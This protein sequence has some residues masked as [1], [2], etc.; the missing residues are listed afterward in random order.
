MTETVK[1][2]GGDWLTENLKYQKAPAPSAFGCDVADVLGCAFCGIYHIREAALFH[3]RTHWHDQN[4]IE[5]VI[6]NTLSTF[7]STEL[8]FLV[9]A[10][11]Q[12]RIRVEVFG[13]AN[14]YLRLTFMR[15]NEG[16]FMRHP[17]PAEFVAK[18]LALTTP[19]PEKTDAP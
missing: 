7:D 15:P 11:I 19:K 13:A 12:R 18:V 3:E 9:L 16:R 10:C 8:T 6:S 2:A 5:L 17:E 14:G 1:F 4:F